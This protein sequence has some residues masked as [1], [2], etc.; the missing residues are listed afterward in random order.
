ML[1]VVFGPLITWKLTSRQIGEARAAEDR[2]RDDARLADEQRRNDERKVSNKQIVAPMR[3]AWINK[4]RENIAELLQA[5]F[6]VASGPGPMPDIPNFVRLVQT[7]AEVELSLNLN[8]DDH[9]KLL[10]LLSQLVAK[11]VEHPGNP[12]PDHW[13]KFWQEQREIRLAAANVL[14]REWDRVKSDDAN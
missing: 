4:L 11:S 2:R 13:I 8:E 3:Q 12:N 5:A 9:K 10:Y 14:K 1:A 7:M 6:Q